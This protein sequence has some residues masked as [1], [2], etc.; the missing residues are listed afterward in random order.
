M[1]KSIA[2]PGPKYHDK[3]VKNCFGI[4]KL[5]S[6]PSKSF[7]FINFEYLSSNSINKDQLVS[8]T[9]DCLEIANSASFPTDFNDVYSHL[10]GGN[11][12]LAFLRYGGNIK[13]FAV[14]DILEINKKIVLHLHG[15]I[16]HPSAQQIG[17]TKKLILNK[18][19]ECQADFLTF[20]THNPRMY[21]VAKSIASCRE[22]VFPNYI[23]KIPEYIIEASKR[24]HFINN[25]NE[26]L[27]VKNAYQD[28]KIQQPVA[29]SIIMQGFEQHV[30]KFDAQAVVV[31]LR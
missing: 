17:N 3:L 19:H 7:P 2:L 31:K 23:E 6:E 16:L 21:A 30:G 24:N 10:F 26:D 13:G 28:E 29:D 20:K 9:K 25:C 8:I 5:K 18:V 14:F 27:V 15:M 1:S 12:E 11:Y 4:S 22:N